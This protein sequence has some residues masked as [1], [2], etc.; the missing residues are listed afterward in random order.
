MLKCLKIFFRIL[1]LFYLGEYFSKLIFD[2]CFNFMQGVSKNINM[3]SFYTVTTRKQYNRRTTLTQYLSVFDVLTRVS[4]RNFLAC[5]CAQ[6]FSNCAQL[7]GV[8]RA[9]NCAQVKSTYVGN[10]SC[11]KANSFTK[12]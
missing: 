6:L 11:Y 8:Y 9:R 12:H 7:L 4:N 2:F 5:N 3:G 10:P 1:R